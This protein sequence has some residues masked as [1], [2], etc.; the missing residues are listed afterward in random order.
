MVKLSTDNQ[1]TSGSIPPS[2]TMLKTCKHHGE[3]V[4][5]IDA[6][7]KYFR[8]RVCRVEAV[9]RR[10]KLVKQKAVDLLGGKCEKCGY[11]H[12]IGA[13]EFHHKDPNHKDFEITS[14]LSW[15]RIE[16]EVLKCTLLCA[17]CHREEHYRIRGR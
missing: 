12:Y 13:L 11:N 15:D 17:N 4:H 7:K 5:V 10:R 6:G 8:C 1:M 9:D 14:S 3:T 16:A 2:S